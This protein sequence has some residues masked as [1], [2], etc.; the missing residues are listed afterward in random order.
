MFEALIRAL[1]YLACLALAFFLTLWVLD[2]IGLNLP[3]MV[4]QCLKVIFI[5]IGV[6]VLY[7]LLWPAVSGIGWFK[8]NSPPK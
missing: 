7:Q 1:I 3:I 4:V 5:L 2:Q 8:S 6:L